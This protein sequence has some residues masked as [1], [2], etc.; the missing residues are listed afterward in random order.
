MTLLGPESRRQL[1]IRTLPN[2][3]LFRRYDTELKLRLRNPRNL[4]DTQ[5]MLQRFRVFLGEM[6]PS[7]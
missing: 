3:E 1:I 4:H 6:P 2:E 7:A 5:V